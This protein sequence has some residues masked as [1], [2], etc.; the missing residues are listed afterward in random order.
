MNNGM[1]RSFHRLF[2]K[3]IGSEPLQVEELFHWLLGPLPEH[4]LNPR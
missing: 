1:L 3:L 2:R 4:P